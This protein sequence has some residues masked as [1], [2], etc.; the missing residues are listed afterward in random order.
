MIKVKHGEKFLVDSMWIY[1]LKMY[2]LNVEEWIM[3][4][5]IIIPWIFMNAIIIIILRVPLLS[6]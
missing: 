2:F 6:P 1:N 4:I 5:Q 3:I